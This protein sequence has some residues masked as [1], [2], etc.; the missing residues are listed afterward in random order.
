VSI[1]TDERDAKRECDE[2]KVVVLRL[3]LVSFAVLSQTVAAT[4]LAQTIH[5]LFWEFDQVKIHQIYT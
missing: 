2:C 1:Y 3:D 4:E 5:R